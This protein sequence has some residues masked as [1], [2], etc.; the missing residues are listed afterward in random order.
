MR[1]YYSKIVS[2]QG[3][4]A[5]VGDW[6]T[7]GGIQYEFSLTVDQLE[8]LGLRREKALKTEKLGNCSIN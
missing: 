1:L 4:I 8:R 2:Y 6:G 7:G 5:K 3:E